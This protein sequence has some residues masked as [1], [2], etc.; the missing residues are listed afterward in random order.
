MVLIRTM[1]NLSVYGLQ[2]ERSKNFADGFDL[3]VWT[4]GA[5]TIVD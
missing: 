2:F 5:V 3:A 4:T 1:L